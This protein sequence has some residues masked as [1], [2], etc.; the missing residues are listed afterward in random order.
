MTSMCTKTKKDQDRCGTRE[1][2]SL[3]QS[4][5]EGEES[6]GIPTWFQ[7]ESGEVQ[8]SQTEIRDGNRGG[9]VRGSFRRGA[10]QS[11]IEEYSTQR[12][13]CRET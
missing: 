4:S 1:K 7:K 13:M 11:G 2:L 12:R 10:G 3:H 5:K 8:G 6:S 9:L